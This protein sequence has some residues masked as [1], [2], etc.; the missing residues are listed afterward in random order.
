MV[1]VL[2]DHGWLLGEHDQWGQERPAARRPCGRRCGMSGPGVPEGV[3]AEQF[4]EFIDLHPTPCANLAGIEIPEGE[5]HGESFTADAG[6]PRPQNIG[7]TPTS[8]L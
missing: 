1:A 5:V 4:V 8:G 2:G 7:T 3:S 6:G